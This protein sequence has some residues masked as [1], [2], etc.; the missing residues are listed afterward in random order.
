MAR[1]PGRERSSVRRR[2][3]APFAGRPLLNRWVLAE[4]GFSGDGLTFCPLRWARL[5]GASIR[6]PFRDRA[7]VDTMLR[8]PQHS[9]DKQELRRV[10]M[11][12]MPH[13]L[14]SVPKVFQAVPVEQWFRGPLA[15]FLSERLSSAR[16]GDP[17]YSTAGG[18]KSAEVASSGT[19][20]AHLDS[21]GNIGFVGLARRC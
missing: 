11:D 17:V 21:V 10:G 2:A 14:A 1:R 4:D 6:F 19:Q 18:R 20:C 9:G 8:L 12:Y 13:D 3:M 16:L 5:G 15:E 7:F